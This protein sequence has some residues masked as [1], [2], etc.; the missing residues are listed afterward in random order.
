MT[1]ETMTVHEAL[2]TLK[3][4]GKRVDKEIKN[5]TFVKNNKASNAKIDGKTIEE[6]QNDIK[7]VYQSICDLIRRR[8]AIRKA[9]TL[10]NATTKVTI[11]DTEMTVAEAIEYNKTGKVFKEELLEV[12]SY[13][14]RSVTQAVENNNGD[15]LESRADDYVQKMYGSK[16]SGVSAEVLSD[17]RKMFIN[18]NTQVIIDPI[19]CKKIIK[20]LSDEIDLFNSKVDSALSVSNAITTI[21][22]T[23]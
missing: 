9:V 12:I 6:Y 21:T 2:S 8:E 20:D 5:A 15:Y 10:S 18:N 17:A 13:Q 19:N 16:E 11:G 3:V 22:V 4:L 1:T 23:Y 7:A 14:Y